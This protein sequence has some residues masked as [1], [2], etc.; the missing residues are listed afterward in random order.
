MTP[1]EG[2]KDPKETPRQISGRRAAKAERVS[3]AKVVGLKFSVYGGTSK[4]SGAMETQKEA[5]KKRD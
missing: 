1:K 3:C 2:S 5:S 4:V